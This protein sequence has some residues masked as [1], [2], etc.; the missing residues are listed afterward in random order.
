MESTD[1]D[2]LRLADDTKVASFFRFLS[3]Y[4]CAMYSLFRGNE[5]TKQAHTESGCAELKIFVNSLVNSDFKCPC[6]RAICNK[7]FR[8]DSEGTEFVVSNM[9]W[10][11]SNMAH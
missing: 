6:L 3:S 7:L 11:R 2:L 9:A 4:I 5:T 10:Y 8:A 1:D